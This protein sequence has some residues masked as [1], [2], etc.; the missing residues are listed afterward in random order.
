MTQ[1]KELATTYKKSLV[2]RVAGWIAL[3]KELYGGQFDPHL[4]PLMNM[5][6]AL[7]RMRVDD[8]NAEAHLICMYGLN[9][10]L[11]TW[12]RNRGAQVL[13][14][15]VSAGDCTDDDQPGG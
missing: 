8:N 1:K 10:L 11:N 13:A 14:I 3:S 12:E 6:W 7:A 2:S 5:S 9:K 15:A 4:K